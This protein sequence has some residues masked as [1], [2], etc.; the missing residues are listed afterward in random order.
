MK[1]RGKVWWTLFSWL[2]DGPSS[3][4]RVW[5]L[6]Y[7]AS[8]PGPPILGVASPGWAD[9]LVPKAAV[10][11]LDLSIT[12]STQPHPVLHAPRRAP[13]P[14]RG[15]TLASGS[16]TLL[17]DG[18]GLRGSGIL[19]PRQPTTISSFIC[20]SILDLSSYRVRA[21]ILFCL[22]TTK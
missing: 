17:L 19:F 3:S 7:W 9:G 13:P 16:E 12:A 8:L 14:G 1:E 21:I 20:L 15:G 22:E 5:W 6:P 11:E 18:L 4:S 2:V 10:Q